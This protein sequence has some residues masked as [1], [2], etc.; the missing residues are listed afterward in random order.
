MKYLFSSPFFRIFIP[1]IGLLF[2]TVLTNKTDFYTFWYF[3]YDGYA[4][5]QQLMTMFEGV[6]TLNPIHLFSFNLN[7]GAP[8]FFMCLLAAL[9]GLI[10][11]ND[12]LFLIG[13]RLIGAGSAIASL[14]FMYKSM[15]LYLDKKLAFWAIL[16]ITLMPGFWIMTQHFRP[17]WALTGIT[18]ACS[19]YLLKDK[20]QYKKSYWIGIAC[21]GLALAVKTQTLF[22][23]PILGLAPVMS[24]LIAPTIATFKESLIRLIK[25]VGAVIVMF[26]AL[27]PHTL[28]PI[29]MY[30]FT[31][32]FMIELG[33]MSEGIPVTFLEKMATINDHIFPSTIYLGLCVLSVILIGYCFREKKN[34]ELIP[35]VA[36]AVIAAGYLLFITAKFNWNYII[37]PS[38]LLLFGLLMLRPLLT[39]KK[40]ILIFSLVVLSIAPMGVQTYLHHAGN[41]PDLEFAQVV[42][43]NDALVLPL[44]KGKITSAMHIGCSQQVL[45]HYNELGLKNQ[46]VHSIFG[47][48][49]WHFRREQHNKRWGMV[50]RLEKKLGLKT[51]TIKPFHDKK[52][53]IM[54]KSQTIRSSDL[55]DALFKNET[56]FQLVGE[57]DLAYVFLHKSLL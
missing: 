20:L 35:V 44:L 56:E 33:R 52:A 15:C 45:F 55:E 3:D 28:H 47:L 12:A 10:L 34:L 49:W 42:A 14:I 23:L 36:G 26:F 40:I 37:S 9:P 6:K 11:G 39:D 53:L 17:D 41:K 38:V 13:P 51:E 50:R 27:N 32:R 18:T 30:G 4:H 8:Y 57:N 7:Y 19:Y 16:P 25:S 43:K 1:L 2:L 29:G 5:Y 31:R 21:F 46:Q 48:G 54:A 22:F 24:F